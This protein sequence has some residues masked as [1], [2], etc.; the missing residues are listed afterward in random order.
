MTLPRGWPDR[1]AL[2]GL[3]YLA[4]ALLVAPPAGSSA[5]LPARL[6]VGVLCALPLVVLLATSPRGSARWGTWVALVMIPYVTLSVGAWLV[7]PA[8]RVPGI[9]F[10]TV[11]STVFFAGILAG[12]RPG[13]GGPAVMPVGETLAEA[14]AEARRY[15]ISGQV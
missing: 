10:A 15:R 11:A 3:A 9:A 5:S 13:R 7:T 2:A 14:T 8:A 6:L 4:A 12:R 1:L